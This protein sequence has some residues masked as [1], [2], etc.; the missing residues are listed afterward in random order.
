MK[1]YCTA[2]LCAFGA[3]APAAHGGDYYGGAEL[4]SDHLV[5]RPEYSFASGRPNASY[6]DQAYG[7]ALG[8]FAGRRWQVGANVSLAVEARLAKSNTA[9]RLALPD[10]ASF[11]YA[12]PYTASLSLLP[13]LGL[14]SRVALYAELGIATGR[15]EQR[16]DAA[17]GSRYDVAQWRP[18]WI[19][20]GGLAFALDD[21][22]GARLGYRR[23]RYA[24]LAYDSRLAD[25]S[26]VESVSCPSV[27]SQWGLGLIRSF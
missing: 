27:Q 16:K 3:I 14:G 25:G 24:S 13:S 22:W 11:T 21:R 26:R 8:V 5:F 6:D 19:A 10:P 4:A 20:G 7:K 18:G 2:A 23:I 12:I 15:I 9:W 17:V 1:R